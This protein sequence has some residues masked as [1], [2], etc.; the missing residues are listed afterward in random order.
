MKILVVTQ[1]FWPESFRINDLVLALRARGHDVNVLTGMPN[2]PGG[3]FFPGYGWFRR[4][5]GS[6]EGIPVRRVPLIPRGRGRGWQL[7]LNY[8]SF[9]ISGSLR[10]L[11][12]CRHDHDVIL[13]F[14][15]SPVT[16]G[17]PAVVARWRTGAPI[18]FWAQD[19]WPET[20]VATGAV[21]SPVILRAVRRLVR[22]I[23]SRCARVLVQSRGFIEPVAAMGVPP[24]RIEV[25]PHWAE[26]FYQPTTV[27]QGA[28]ERC[29]MGDGFKVVFAGNIGMAQSFETIL[30]AAEHLRAQ[31]DIRWVV[32][33]SGHREAWL[34]EQI[35]A[36]GLDGEFVLLGPRPSEA[37]PRYFAA[38]DAL[39]VTLRRDP[40]F[41]LT[42]PSK[43][44]SYLACGR[45][46]IAALDGEGARIVTEA[47]A[48]FSS[49]AQNGQALADAVLALSQLPESERAAMGDRG[50]QYSQL[51][52]SRDR[53]MDHLERW[54]TEVATG[55][56]CAS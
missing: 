43:L 29:E 37:M 51:H 32:I 5:R 20:L 52:F 26:D 24:K 40:A 47:G 14:E 35:R 22:F 15:P 1:Y 6:F 56:P 27:E 11:C 28:P 30:M 2:Y 4:A 36:R 25:I 12:F 49:P 46:V 9:A 55:T 50:R 21:R 13:V 48:G 31:S 16:V 45:P 41:A 8:F 3:S 7:A 53:L 34:R 19:L 54:M 17:L 44:Q 23:Y 42:I 33:G 10:A 38:A 39:L 18:L